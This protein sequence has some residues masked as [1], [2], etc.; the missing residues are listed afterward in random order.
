MKTRKEMI[1]EQQEKK[2]KERCENFSQSL[3]LLTNASP[4]TNAINTMRN[5]EEEIANGPVP[6]SK[7]DQSIS[8]SSDSSDSDS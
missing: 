7:N 6:F 8:L 2:K 5:K 4:V 3:D 1:K